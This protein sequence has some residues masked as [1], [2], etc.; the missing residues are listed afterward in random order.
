VGHI[1]EQ[2]AAVIAGSEAAQNEWEDEVATGFVIVHTL[3]VD[4]EVSTTTTYGPY[5]NRLSALSRLE[6][7]EAAFSAID[8]PG[9][10]HQRFVVAPVLDEQHALQA[11]APER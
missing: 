9:Q 5:P 3:T 8:R 1:D 4:D 6:A 2:H 11:A 7:F 10:V